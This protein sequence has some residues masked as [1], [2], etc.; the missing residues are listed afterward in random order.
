MLSQKVLVWRILVWRLALSP[1]PYYYYYYFYYY[2][3]YY[4]YNNSKHNLR[5]PGYEPAKPWTRSRP[6]ALRE[7]ER[8]A[9]L[10][11]PTLARHSN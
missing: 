11:A 9:P 4:Y 10:H 5:R 7:E 1:K 3:Y 2:Y 6:W 8:D